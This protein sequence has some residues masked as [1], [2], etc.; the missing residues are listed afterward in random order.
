MAAA[1]LGDWTEFIAAFSVFLL[2]HAIPARPAVRAGL[3][4][5]LGERW[6]LV[7]YSI[8]ALAVLYWLIAAAGRAP[9]SRRTAAPTPDQ[10]RPTTSRRFTLMT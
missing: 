10:M 4:A 5:R 2:S 9:W 1:H 6:F 3:I 7:A 8:F